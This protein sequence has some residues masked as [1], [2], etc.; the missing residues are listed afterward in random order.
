MAISF[1]EERLHDVRL[2]CAARYMSGANY[3]GYGL[4]A[5]FTN[6]VRGISYYGFFVS[7]TGEC[8]LLKV[9]NGQELVLADWTLSPAFKTSSVNTLRLEC[10][11]G[12]VRA[13][14]NGELALQARD[15]LLPAGGYALLAGPG[16]NVR[17]DDLTLSG[18]PPSS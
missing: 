12:Q 3:V 14:V 5:R 1:Q 8:L 2:E 13:F 7:Q 10:S 17:F 16:V 9:E 18:I 15:N 6:T 4:A 11:G